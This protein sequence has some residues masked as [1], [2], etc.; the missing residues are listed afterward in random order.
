MQHEV[1]QQSFIAV[2]LE[3]T[4]NIS[5]STCLKKKIHVNYSRGFKI[6]FESSI[7]YLYKSNIR[8]KTQPK[9]PIT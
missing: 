4:E 3:V 5:S 6:Y 9:S 8:V 7:I 1:Y 2:K